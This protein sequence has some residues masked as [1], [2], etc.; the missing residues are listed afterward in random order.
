V[1]PPGELRGVVR[2]LPGGKSVS[3]ATITVVGTKQKAETDSDGVFKILLAPGQ[4]KIKVTSKGLKDQELD[5]TVDPN[6]VAIKN[7][8]LQK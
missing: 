3:G 4:Y 5:V 8:D 6:G 7:I 1:L 2:S